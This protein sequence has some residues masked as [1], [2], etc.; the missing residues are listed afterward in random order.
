M[1]FKVVQVKERQNVGTSGSISL[2]LGSQPKEGNLLVCFVGTDQS[3]DPLRPNAVLVSHSFVDAWQSGEKNLN[4]LAD[5]LK[6][7]YRIA[8]E[9]ESSFIEVLTNNSNNVLTMVVVEFETTD[10][11]FFLGTDVFL[12]NDG[13][14]TTKT[15]GP[16]SETNRDHLLSVV[17]FHTAGAN[18]GWSGSWTNGFEEVV[19]QPAGSSS[20]RSMAVAFRELDKTQTLTTETSTSGSQDWGGVLMT[21]GLKAQAPKVSE[22]IK[23]IQ[24]KSQVETTDTTLMTAVLDSTPTP[25]NLLVCMVD[26]IAGNPERDNQ[27]LR[28][29]AS[30]IESY[31]IIGNGS[32]SKMFA[33]IAGESEPTSITSE[34]FE[35]NERSMIVAEFSG[36][37]DADN[38]LEASAGNPETEPFPSKKRVFTGTVEDA[39][40]DGLAV[41]HFYALGDISLWG[42]VYENTFRNIF[43]QGVTGSATDIIASAAYRITNLEDSYFSSVWTGTTAITT[44]GGIMTIFRAVTVQPDEP[45][46]I[47]AKV[48]EDGC[49]ISECNSPTLT[50]PTGGEEIATRTLD[51]Q[52]HTPQPH[53][54]SGMPVW[55]EIFFTENYDPER[56]QKN[57]QQ[58][59]SVP[60]GPTS[61]LWKIP[62]AI[63]SSKCRMA[64]RCRDHRGIRGPLM[65]APDNFTIRDRRIA[66]PAIFSPEEG[67]VH[68]FFVPIVFDNQGLLETQS[69]RASFQIFYS[70]Q[71]Q[72]IDWTLIT[73][74]T[75]VGSEPIFF[76]IRDLPPSDDY[77]FKISLKDDSGDESV[78]IFIRNMTFSPLNYFILDTLPPRGTVTVQDNVEFVNTRDLILRLAAFDDAT[79]VQ[80]VTLQQREFG[81]DAEGNTTEEV[82]LDRPDQEFSNVNTW[83]ITG[84]DGI[85]RIEALFKDYAGNEPPQTDGQ[86]A[87]RQFLNN[88]NSPI[89]TILLVRS[90]SNLDVWTA[91][92]GDEPVLFK[93]QSVAFS[94]DGEPTAL[95]FF[96]FNVFVATATDTNTGVLQR[97]VADE[98]DDIKEF[99]E[100]DSI[101]NTMAVFNNR[102]YIGLQNGEL[103]SFDGTV[104]NLVQDM[105]SAVNKLDADGSLLYIFLDNTED[106][107]I[108]DGLSFTNA[109][110]INGN[111][112]V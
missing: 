78:P 90:G 26:A 74:N 47:G 48:A 40:Q 22:E 79:G 31:F 80:S 56:A 59:A 97:I 69:Q 108:F 100:F 44:Y 15:I 39:G 63:K 24:F 85:K 112:Q 60:A 62:F 106:I 52:W 2:T 19:S 20:Q 37:W 46:Q 29:D 10:G 82:A 111:N 104:V 102:L 57:W 4:G 92:G 88:E 58:I 101:I 87:F 83:F 25:G 1:S 70:S 35:S 67:S 107:T 51:I 18:G 71:K 36:N 5:T 105:G 34:G 3:A 55:H 27:L 93:N 50:F 12:D 41:A 103:H 6:T 32:C 73:Q 11:E 21:F 91:F 75:P 43:Q 38:L 13:S 33:K 16:T 98:L 94:L 8:G 30:W 64:I 99:T 54:P 84:D 7:Y 53:H 110:I 96:N 14:G 72:N 95:E 109:G 65:V 76:D 81:T 23:L 86:K 45:G 17:A 66:S 68:R 9:N 77:E 89:G 42:S 28:P 49:L 61:F